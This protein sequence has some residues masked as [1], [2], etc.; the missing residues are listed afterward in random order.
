MSGLGVLQVSKSHELCR[1]CYRRLSYSPTSS[2]P[3][4]VRMDGVGIPAPEVLA[5]VLGA[6]CQEQFSGRVVVDRHSATLNA[7]ALQVTRH[8]EARAL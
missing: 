4:S 5:A 1:S 3:C 8:Y 6:L 2:P 7:V